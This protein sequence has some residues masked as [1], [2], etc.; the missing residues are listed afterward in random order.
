[1]SVTLLV[2]YKDINM[3]QESFIKFV[4]FTNMETDD[5]ETLLKVI[6]KIHLTS[7]TTLHETYFDKRYIIE[8]MKIGEGCTNALKRVKGHFDFKGNHLSS[9]SI[10][11][12]NHHLRK[13]IK[14]IG[15]VNSQETLEEEFLID[16]NDDSSSC[17][18]TRHQ[19]MLDE[20]QKRT[21]KLVESRRKPLIEVLKNDF[22][23]LD[24]KISEKHS[25]NDVEIV[26]ISEKT[27]KSFLDSSGKLQSSWKQILMHSKP[28]HPKNCSR[29]IEL[30]D[31]DLI[32]MC[33]YERTSRK[34]SDNLKIVEHYT[35]INGV[36]KTF[37][38]V[39]VKEN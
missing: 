32:L 6:K 9:D 10:F 1:M 31:L 34:E 3:S 18:R 12:L 16:L 20:Y 35:W 11:Y 22:N 39:M 33:T 17:R 8:I 27:L 37:R 24:S 4:V 15:W 5:S 25:I 21:G 7:Y 26:G 36:K 28:I 13:L 19:K 14:D 29:K 23:G 38:I 2:Y 30:T